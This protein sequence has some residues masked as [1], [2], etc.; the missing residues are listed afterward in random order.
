MGL[1]FSPLG[2]FAWLRNSKHPERHQFLQ[3]A[4]SDGGQACGAGPRSDLT[5]DA[6]GKRDGMGCSELLQ[7]CCSCHVFF[8]YRHLLE[9]PSSSEIN[10]PKL[11]YKGLCSWC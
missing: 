7:L 11:F 8:V 10:A 4:E 3:R 6:A 1:C 2:I 5:R 9:L